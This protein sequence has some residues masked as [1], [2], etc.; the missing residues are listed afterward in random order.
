[1]IKTIHYKNFTFI[2]KKKQK[3]FQTYKKKTKNVQKHIQKVYIVF[4]LEKQDKRPT[5][6]AGAAA[7]AVSAAAVA[8][9]CCC[10]C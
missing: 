2:T 10:C 4:P 5:G 1:M 8:C 6:V 3:Q 9:S 7:A